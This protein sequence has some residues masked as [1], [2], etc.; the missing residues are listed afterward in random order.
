MYCDYSIKDNGIKH[1][2]RLI[3]KPCQ[4][5]VWDGD[6]Q[7]TWV[8]VV[9]ANH[10]HLCRKEWDACKCE[11]DWEDIETRHKEFEE[12]FKG[13]RT[14][15]LFEIWAAQ[16]LQQLPS[17][18]RRYI[19]MKFLKRP[20]EFDAAALYAPKRRKRRC[21][22]L[23]RMKHFERNIGSNTTLHAFQVSSF[24]YPNVPERHPNIRH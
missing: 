9:D 12:D 1:K 23:F 10:C 15:L 2:S 14:Q 17:V 18:L 24:I 21:C 19:V 6:R 11:T 22:G 8:Y 7:V 3:A 16:Q 4:V 20:V 5:A 13:F